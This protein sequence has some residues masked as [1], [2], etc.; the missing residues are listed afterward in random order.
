MMVLMVFMT[1]AAVCMNN[2]RTLSFLH[3]SIILGH[4]E[5]GCTIILEV[6]ERTIM[7]A[8]SSR[9]ASAW[10]YYEI[11]LRTTARNKCFI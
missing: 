8:Q 6:R 1:M 9:N 11:L 7:T 2:T 4:L 10:A 5:R 3:S